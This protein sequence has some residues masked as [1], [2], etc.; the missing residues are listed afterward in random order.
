MLYVARWWVIAASGTSGRSG[1][2]EVSTTPLTSDDGGS[3]SSRW[4]CA[5]PMKRPVGV[6]IG[7]R[8]T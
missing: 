3:R 2:I 7:G 4:M 1:S 8:H 5:M 6:S